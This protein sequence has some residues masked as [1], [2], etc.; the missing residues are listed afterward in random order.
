[1]FYR[2]TLPLAIAAAGDTK[3]SF[4]SDS[5]SSIIPFDSIPLILRG[6]RLAT[7]LTCKPTS[8]SGAALNDAAVTVFP[9]PTADIIAIQVSGLVAETL[10]IALYSLEGRWLAGSRLLAGQTISYLDAQPL[11][12]GTYVVAIGQGATAITRQVV[13]SRP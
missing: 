7:T 9:N 1:M 6:A 3:C 13:I 2:I 8:D 10:P 12:N 5:A 11:Y 4:P